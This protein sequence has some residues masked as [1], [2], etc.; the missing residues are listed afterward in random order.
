MSKKIY[1]GLNK[2]RVNYHINS[3]HEVS[4]YKSVCLWG[5]ESG[6][7]LRSF[8]FHAQQLS[9]KFILLIN[10]KMPTIVGILTL[11]S[12]INTT[13]EFESKKNLF[14]YFTFYEQLKFHAQLRR[15]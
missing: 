10:V 3:H 8:F 2:T 5:L 4:Y 6:L 7:E 13:S 14:H 1:R 9:I 12:R 11:I 15:A